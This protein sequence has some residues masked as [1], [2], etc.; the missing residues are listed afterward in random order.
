MLLAPRLFSL[1]LPIQSAGVSGK[2]KYNYSK[3][4]ANFTDER[5]SITPMRAKN[6]AFAIFPTPLISHYPLPLSSARRTSIRPPSPS[7]FLVTSIPSQHNIQILHIDWVLW[8]QNGF[9][10]IHFIEKK[11]LVWSPL[12]NSCLVPVKRQILM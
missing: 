1:T 10:F 12:W 9:L 5:M 7:I 8:Q 2:R 11:K 3:M 4:V 6:Q